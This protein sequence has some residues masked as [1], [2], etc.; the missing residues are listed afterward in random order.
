[1]T[2]TKPRSPSLM[3]AVSTLALAASTFT[4]GGIA[5]LIPALVDQRGMSLA[6]AGI[7]A[8]APL[9]GTMV[10]LFAWGVAV[11]RVGERA[12]LSLGLALSTFAGAGATLAA[13]NDVWLAIF[14]FVAGMTSA[15]TN[16]ATGRLIVGAFAVHRRGLAMGIRQAALPVAVGLAAVSI[17]VIAAAHG[18]RTA[19][20]VAPTL[21]AVAAIA[22]YLL[23]RDPSR[24]TRAQ[25][26]ELGELLN[27][28][29]RIPQLWRIHAASILL[30]I[31]QFTVWTFSLVWLIS[32]R[33]WS[34][35]A[36]GIFVAGT[37]LLSAAGRIAAG[38][39][40]DRMGSR[41]RPM[42]Y[43][44]VA[45]ALSMLT[46]GI[47]ESTPLA[48]AVLVVASTVSVID[49]GLAYTAVAELSGPFWSGRTLGLHNTL[50]FAASAAVPP[51]LGA[52][53]TG[54]GYGLAFAVVAIFP[55]IAIP[56]VPVGH[57]D[58]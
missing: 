4:T 48:I 27:P 33:D 32:E 28:Y 18:I 17:P 37:Q 43:I 10:T 8:A 49:N 29:R 35:A 53:I 52:F 15:G 47:L 19:L 16:S 31:P 58:V 56:L 51:L 1:M 34:P 2:P 7:I 55:L 9:A 44:A 42:R 5:F 41:M 21:C 57:S 39:W 11:D 26:H 12:V 13:A 24:P 54:Y 6:E 3:L 40:S 50:Q 30:V 22:S 23:I 46:L 38:H 25:A 14:L 20:L 36:A 45:A